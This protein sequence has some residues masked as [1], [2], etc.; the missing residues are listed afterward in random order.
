MLVDGRKDF[1]KIAVAYRDRGVV[2][3]NRH[4]L[5]FR[6]CSVPFRTRMGRV[7]MAALPE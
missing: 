4:I 1:R 3:H 6:Y 2:V 7:D 5:A